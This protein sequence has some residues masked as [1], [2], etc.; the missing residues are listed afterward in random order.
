MSLECTASPV[1]TGGPFSLAGGD[2]RGSA[3][4]EEPR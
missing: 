3:R 1:D 4:R 2:T